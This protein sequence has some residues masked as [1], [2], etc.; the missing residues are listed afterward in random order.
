MNCSSLFDPLVIDNAEDTPK[1]VQINK[2]IAALQKHIFRPSLLSMRRLTGGNMQTLMSPVKEKM[3]SL[4][5]GQ[6]VYDKKEIFVLSDGGH[7]I[8]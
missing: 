2:G 5:H 4:V 3:Q 7:I 6:M 1:S 8:I